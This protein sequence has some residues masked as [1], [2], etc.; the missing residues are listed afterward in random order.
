[1]AF[2]LWRHDGYRS[3]SAGGLHFLVLGLR[4]VGA[5][6]GGGGGTSF[7]NISRL[8]PHLSGD[9]EKLAVVVEISGS[10]RSFIGGY[11]FLFVSWTDVV[12]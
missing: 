2:G 1:V 4:F 5:C 12:F 3:S 10:S 6:S 8:Q 11:F 9:V 7:N